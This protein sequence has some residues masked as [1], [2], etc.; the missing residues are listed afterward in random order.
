M[1]CPSCHEDNDRVR[2]SRAS[3]DGF[4]IRRRRVCSSCGYRYT[5]YERIEGT[6]VK[7]V[8]K[9]GTH[10]QGPRKNRLLR[11][12]IG[13]AVVVFVAL[14]MGFLVVVV[15]MMR[16]MNEIPN[17]RSAVVL[18][19]VTCGIEFSF[20]VTAISL[21]VAFPTGILAIGLIAAGLVKAHR[22]RKRSEPD[23]SSDVSKPQ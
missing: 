1:K 5:T 23:K 2:D 12:D 3:H 17:F 16:S 14:A 21:A 6:T 4:A 13:F 19:R 9:D 20:D 7:I 10:T 22:D 8:E 18:D 11:M 15:S